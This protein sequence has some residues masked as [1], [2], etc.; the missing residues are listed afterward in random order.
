I[1]VEFYPP[2][3][4]ELNAIEVCWKIT[5]AN[6]TNSIHYEKIGDMQEAIEDFLDNH[7][8]KLNL[9]HYLCP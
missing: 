1:N 6:V 9:S 3:S 5:R 8:F 2:Y 4:P 7:F